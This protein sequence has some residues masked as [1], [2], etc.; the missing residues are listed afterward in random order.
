MFLHS[1]IIVDSVDIWCLIVQYINE[2]ETPTNATRAPVTTDLRDCVLSSHRCAARVCLAPY[3][4]YI[5]FCATFVFPIKYYQQQSAVVYQEQKESFA[6]LC[7]FTVHA[8]AFV[9]VV[10]HMHV[11]RVMQLDLNS[12]NSQSYFVNNCRSG[13]K[14][15]SP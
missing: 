13:K 3:L 6:C 9:I 4:R 15:I 11:D 1:V 2:V 14:R 8:Y 5:F 12:S 10:K 7:Y